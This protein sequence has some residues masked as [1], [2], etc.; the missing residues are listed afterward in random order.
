MVT[1]RRAAWSGRPP[2]DP[3]EATDRLIDAAIACVARRGWE[4]T[5]MSDI[6]EAAGVS[7]PTLYAHFPR[8]EVILE[9]AMERAANQLVERICALAEG[10]V[11]AA[12]YVV[13]AMMAALREFPA[14]PVLSLIATPGP[15]S[16]SWMPD[17]VTP[18]A[19]SVGRRFLAPLEDL[20]PGLGP[21]LDEITE[22]TIR[23]LLSL[24]L[25]PNPQPRPD[26]ELRSYLHRRLVPALG[27]DPAGMAA[28]AS[29][30]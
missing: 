28:R 3:E 6:A 12:D 17:S 13:E 29:V 11:T 21:E 16:A 10:A 23:F 15:E 4:R 18:A 14:D 30:R 25:F 2:V 26:A 7:R 9:A 24:L 1:R 19:V 8:R 27:L 5:S 22:T 20:A